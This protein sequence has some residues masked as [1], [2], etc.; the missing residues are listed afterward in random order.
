[1]HA[2]L[3]DPQRLA[4]VEELLLGDRSPAWFSRHWG[5]A[6]N[7]VAHHTNVL[8][9]AGLVERRRSEADQRRRYLHLTDTGRALAELPAITDAQRVVF[10]C[11][12]NSARSQ[13][14]E[15]LWRSTSAIPAA[16]GGTEPAARVHPLA[17]RVAERHGVDLRGAAPKRTG[18]LDGALVVTVC[19]HADERTPAPHRHWSVPDPVADGGEA[20]FEAAWEDIADRVETLASMLHEEDA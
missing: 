2:A 10:V 15:A 13:F 20:A 8:A 6:S 17:R 9:E 3:A 12:H 5:V 7:L 18:A 11:T 16:S 1:M 14:A 4:I 19:D